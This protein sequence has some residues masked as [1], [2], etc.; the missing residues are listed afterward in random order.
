MA[1]RPTY[2][3][4]PPTTTAT[5][6]GSSAQT[7]VNESQFIVN[8]S[9]EWGRIS[10][11]ISQQNMGTLNTISIDC[12]MRITQL[13]KNLS[14]TA[15]SVDLSGYYQLAVLNTSLNEQLNILQIANA[16]F[17]QFQ[18]TVKNKMNSPSQNSHDTTASSTNTSASSTLSL[19]SAKKVKETIKKAFPRQDHM[20]SFFSPI[21]P[22]SNARD[23]FHNPIAYAFSNNEN[24]QKLSFNPSEQEVINASRHS[25]T[26]CMTTEN[27]LILKDYYDARKQMNDPL[28]TLYQSISFEDFIL[29]LYN[30]R[31]KEVY[32]DGRA[33][34]PRSPDD[35]NNT[36]KTLS[37]SFDATISADNSRFNTILN[38]ALLKNI[39]TATDHDALYKKYL[40]LEETVL[41]T[42][43]IP[44]A[45]C[46]VIGTGSRTEETTWDVTAELAQ[47]IDAATFSYPAAAEFRD[48]NTLHYDLLFIA[49][50]ANPTAA[51]HASITTIKNNPALIAA[52]KK[53]YGEPLIFE[54]EINAIDFVTIPKTNWNIYKPAYLQ[55]TVNMLTN[56]LLSADH[57]ITEKKLGPVYQLK[58]LG[59]GAFAFKEGNSILERLYIE[60]LKRTLENVS[61]QLQ[62]IKIINLTN[63]PSSFANKATHLMN[64]LPSF[65]NKAEQDTNPVTCIA[66]IQGIQVIKT[67][68]DPSTQQYATI[69]GDIGGITV[70][71]D[72]GSLFGNE[73]NI[74]LGRNSSDDPASQYSILDPCILNAAFNPTLLDKK[75]ITVIPEAKHCTLTG[76]NFELSKGS[77]AD[78]VFA[79]FT[80]CEQATLF[81]TTYKIP[82]L[83]DETL[84]KTLPQP[85]ASRVTGYWIVRIPYKGIK[86]APNYYDE[87]RQAHPELKL[88][89][90]A[91]IAPETPFQ[92]SIAIPMST[93]QYTTFANSSGIAPAA[94]VS[95][96]SE[97]T[98][99]VPETTA[100]PPLPQQMT[101]TPPET[102]APEQ[103]TTI[104]PTTKN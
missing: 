99:T 79:K 89:P 1:Q 28:G 104:V 93:S 74:G 7:T 37:S 100:T 33:L 103:V 6:L 90:H 97:S 40:T 46:I 68:M 9:Q 11:A 71:G 67:K 78:H 43:V 19:P 21:K 14:A 82:E 20:L 49:K 2:P 5:E 84:G 56:L 101:A 81:A 48:G 51:Y 39:G 10:Q 61:A 85:D 62:S 63:L 60:A 94:I 80:T 30:N 50:P 92:P 32:F 75:C 36:K 102:T 64:F 23:P 25:A 96:T 38:R 12:M 53:I 17:Q 34:V 59:L 52:A 45:T 31:F 76:W 15:G 24:P 98:P 47:S 65:P 91:W 22:R 73:G 86:N 72:S 35:F 44:Q 66:I 95:T 77:K 88:P 29:R 54:K 57:D 13:L 18:A 42:L 27:Q 83:F 8:L 55:R 69:I 3:L 87:F 26:L 41:S 58:G 4:S 16:Q 70:C